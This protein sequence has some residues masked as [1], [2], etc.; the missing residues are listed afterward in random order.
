ML[1]VREAGPDLRVRGAEAHAR[2]G[3]A[4]TCLHVEPGDQKGWLIDRSVDETA[5]SC[6]P[7]PSY[8][9][10][11]SPNRA[12][13]EYTPRICLRADPPLSVG[14]AMAP[15]RERP[16]VGGSEMMPHMT[17]ARMPAPSPTSAAA[18]W[19]ARDNKRVRFNKVLCLAAPRSESPT[20]LECV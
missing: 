3:G 5:P 15:A 1:A 8:Q 19:A 4:F 10:T 9:P 6:Q 12:Q 11:I 17:A 13:Q 18:T 14:G 2:F 7:T 20:T 16:H